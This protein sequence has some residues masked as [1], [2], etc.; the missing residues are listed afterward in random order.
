MNEIW[1]VRHGETEWSLTGQHTGR[2]DLPLTD[3]GKVAAQSLAPRLSEISFDRVLTSP[4]QRA[5]ET[6]RL[7]GFPHAETVDELM[8]WNYGDFEGRTTKEIR[9]EFP[10]WTVWQGPIPNGES[11]EQV[12][13][14]ANA[15][16]ERCREGKVAVFAHGHILRVLATCWLGV[17]P[18]KGSLLALSTASLSVLGWEHETRV[19]RAWNL[20]PHQI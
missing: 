12:A 19:I 14:R 5:G 7:A 4:L 17:K 16:L 8:E 13:A 1:L 10:H 15:V 9:A 6:A 3:G 11:L 2:T 18:L 20:A